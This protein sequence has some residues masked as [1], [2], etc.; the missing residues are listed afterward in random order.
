MEILK[1][2]K[3]LAALNNRQS[4]DGMS[5]LASMAEV[6]RINRLIEHSKKP[7]ITVKSKGLGGPGGRP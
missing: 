5:K 6:R 1:S 3:S 2:K 4:F 7:K